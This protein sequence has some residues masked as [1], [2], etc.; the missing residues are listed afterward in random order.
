M[1]YKNPM[2]I[3]SLILGGFPVGDGHLAGFVDPALVGHLLIF[4][5]SAWKN[6]MGAMAKRREQCHENHGKKAPMAKRYLGK[7]PWHP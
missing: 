6:T 4:K 7:L 1:Y 3:D 2:F 5:V